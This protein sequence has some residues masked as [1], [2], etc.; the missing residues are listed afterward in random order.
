MQMA[1]TPKAW[2][3][4]DLYAL[5]DNGYTYEF[6]RGELFVTPA[7]GSDHQNIGMRLM[8]LLVPYVQA[9]GLGHV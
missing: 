1:T 8:R 9:N 6:V 5:P 2:T 3:L 7:S 4:E